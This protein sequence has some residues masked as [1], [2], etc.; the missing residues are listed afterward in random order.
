MKMMDYIKEQPALLSEVLSNR[1]KLCCN[2]ADYYMNIDP[3]RIYIIASGTSRNA[4]LAASAFVSELLGIDVIVRAS[5]ENGSY[6]GQKPFII[7]ISQG[8]NSTNTIKAIRED[9]AEFTIAMT[10]N[11]EGEINKICKNYMEI[12]C[13][14]ETAG[15]KTKGYTVTI[16]TLYLMALETALCKRLI[17]ERDYSKYIDAFE[18][19]FSYLDENITRSIEFTKQNLSLLKDVKCLY[20]IGKGLDYRIALEGALKVMETFLIPSFA[21]EFEEYLHGPTCSVDV[22]ISGFYL[23]TD[24]EKDQQRMKSLIAYHKELNH[25]VFSVGREDS[26]DKRD[27]VLKLSDSPYVRVFE[28]I[29]PLQV[30]S[31]IVPESLGIGDVGSKRFKAIDKILGVKA[32][33]E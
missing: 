28:Y 14:I 22:N 24:D 20:V 8:G 9:N 10:G 19:S 18:K 15:P 21:F 12:P 33:A 13:G 27:L 29:I 4:A 5:S 23:Y 11:K 3:D 25:S 31:S 17:C 32:K 30:I 16:L 1:K 6:L 2:F 7:Y 26:V